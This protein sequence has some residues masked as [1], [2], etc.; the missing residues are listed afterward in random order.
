MAHIDYYFGLL[1]PWA[2]LAG[3]RL[4]EIAAR[5]GATITYKPVDLMQLFDRTGGVRRENRHPARLQYG[6]QDLARWVSILGV[7]FNMNPLHRSANMA[8]ASYAVIAAQKAGGGDLGGLIQSL[9]AGVWAEDKDI[10]D[11]AV[12]SAKLAEHGF[13]SSLV[14]SGLLTGAETYARNL[15]EAVE[16]GVFGSPFYII[17]DTDERFWGQERLTMLDASLA[18]LK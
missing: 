15:D 7:P 13:D 5:Y 10:S 1:S 3:P 4:E 9:M 18:V 11:D 12:I 8:P 16:A 17:T 6:A 14:N 2:Y